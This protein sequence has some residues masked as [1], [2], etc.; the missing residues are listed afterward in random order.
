[1]KIRRRTSP[2][3]W[4]C[5][6]RILLLWQRIIGVELLI[7]FSRVCCSI[8]WYQVYPELISISPSDNDSS[9]ELSSS[10]DDS[11]G[12]LSFTCL[13]FELFVSAVVDFSSGFSVR[14]TS[15]VVI[16]FKVAVAFNFSNAC[17]AA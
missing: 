1:M 14:S 2:I 11:A 10:E 12:Y 4:R 5:P 7:L 15:S 3:Q 6:R 13:P 17:I 16:F 8:N 9:D